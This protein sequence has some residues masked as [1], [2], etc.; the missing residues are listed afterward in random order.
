MKKVFIIHGFAATPNGGWRTWL[1][2]ELGNKNIYACALPMPNPSQPVCAEWTAEIKRNIDMNKGDEIYLVG[3]SLGST[4]ILRY[5]ESASS[6]P[7]AGAVLVSGPTTKNSR[8]EL[9]NFL[10]HYFDYAKI[11]A[12][13]KKFAVIHGDNDPNVP[14]SNAETLSR[15][16]GVEPLIIKNGGHLAGHDGFHTFPQCLDALIKIMD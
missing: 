14:L 4:A 13:A 11:K 9:D 10:D 3:H 16:L 7:I 5:L 8:R 1:M 15:E 6:G 2:S 12:G